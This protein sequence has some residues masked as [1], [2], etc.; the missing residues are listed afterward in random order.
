MQF[1]KYQGLGNDFVILDAR[2]SVAQPAPWPNAELARQLCDRRLGVGADGVLWIMEGPKMV[3]LNADGSRPEACGNGLRC[4]ALYLATTDSPAADPPGAASKPMDLII[5]TD[6]GPRRCEV[7]SDGQV[8]AQMGDARFPAIP[9]LGPDVAVDVGNPHRVCFVGENDPQLVAREGPILGRDPAFEDGCNVGFAR[10][11]HDPADPTT[12]ILSLAVW[13]RGVGPTQ[14]CGSGACA[15]AAAA[16]RR[17][18]LPEGPIRVDQPGGTLIIEIGPPSP[19]D[20]ARAVTM[21]GPASRVFAGEYLE[22]S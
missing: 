21:T 15:A 13:E 7:R 4:V 1:A 10:L 9:G 3:V 6:A 18:V 5:G 11:A 16:V 22:R 12:P 20:G 14:A 2:P 8:R 19:E 17:D